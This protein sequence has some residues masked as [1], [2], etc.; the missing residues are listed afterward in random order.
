MLNNV[1]LVR[2]GVGNLGNALI[3]VEKRRETMREGK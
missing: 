2:P 1:V 3:S